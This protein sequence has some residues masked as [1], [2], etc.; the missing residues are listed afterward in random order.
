MR[1]MPLGSAD[2]Q[3]EVQLGNVRGYWE[4]LR[5]CPALPVSTHVSRARLLVSPMGLR[6]GVVFSAIQACRSPDGFG[7]EPH[8]MSGAM[9]EGDSQ[10][11]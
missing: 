2:N 4:T 10:P 5:T 7:G 6:P 3:H 9:L 11:D 8:P 1:R